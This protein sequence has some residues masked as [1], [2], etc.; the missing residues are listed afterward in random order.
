MPVQKYGGANHLWLGSG[1]LLGPAVAQGRLH[2]ISEIINTQ[3]LGGP[4]G[5]EEDTSM[6]I[7]KEEVTSMHHLSTMPRLLQPP[8]SLRVPCPEGIRQRRPRRERVCGRTSVCHGLGG[9][10]I[11]STGDPQRLP[12]GALPPA[13]NKPMDWYQDIARYAYPTASYGKGLLLCV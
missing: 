3:P 8:L 4:S 7:S 11:I 6:P 1:P 12:G 9:A 13:L 5:R 2:H 10:S